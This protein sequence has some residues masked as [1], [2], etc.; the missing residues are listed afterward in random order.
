MREGINFKLSRDQTALLIIDV[1]EKLFP[2]VENSCHVMQAMQK[3]LRAFQIL[4]LPVYVSEQYPKGL[5]STVAALKGILGDKQ[6]YHTKSAFSCLDDE[7]LKKVIL[8]SS[9]TQW[10]LIG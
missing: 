4:A 10:V 7:E 5:G 6:H 3:A 8:L 1:Q 2:Y 9:I